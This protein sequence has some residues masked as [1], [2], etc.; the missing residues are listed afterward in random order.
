MFIFLLNLEYVMTKQQRAR[1]K[2][3]QSSKKTKPVWTFNI[4]KENYKWFA[5]GIG[6]IIIGYILL[7]TGITEEPALPQG[8]WNNPLAVYIAPIVL[9]VGYC[10]IIPYALL[11]SFKKKQEN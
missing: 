10:V 9:V 2:R 11:K 8:K 7:A 1:G 3:I 6:V 5:I 4:E